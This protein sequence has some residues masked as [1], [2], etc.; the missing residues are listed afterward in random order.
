M[1]AY[2]DTKNVNYSKLD[3]PEHSGDKIGH[4]ENDAESLDGRSINLNLKLNNEKTD[5]QEFDNNKSV[6]IDYSNLD[7]SKNEIQDEKKP[8]EFDLDIIGR[9]EEQMKQDI[10]TSEIKQEIKNVRKA[11]HQDLE[12]EQGT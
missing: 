1:P 3:Q 7:L 4:E 9:I 8:N 6:K 12:P 5:Q 11:L 2:E 10:S